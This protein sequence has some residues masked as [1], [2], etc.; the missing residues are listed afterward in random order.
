MRR[1]NIEQQTITTWVKAFA[2]KFGTH[3]KAYTQQSSLNFPSFAITDCRLEYC[4][5]LASSKGFRKRFWS[6]IDTT[7]YTLLAGFFF[8]SPNS[9]FS[10]P[11]QVAD[12]LPFT[13]P[14]NFK[15]YQTLH[16]VWYQLDLL[17]VSSCR[18]S[19]GPPPVTANLI[20]FNSG[21]TWI[22]I[23]NADRYTLRLPTLIQPAIIF[24]KLD[25]SSLIS[26]SRN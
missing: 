17:T 8:V 26:Y 21:R 16:L 25:L 3:Y 6:F 18:G 10:L 14:N 9:R 19:S 7:A 24:I 2:V 4:L 22:K 1:L 11:C 5:I 12:F 23:I 15:I 20:L 13:S